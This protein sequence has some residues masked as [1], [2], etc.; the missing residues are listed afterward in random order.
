VTRS[1]KE[2]FELS[3]GLDE[4]KQRFINRIHNQVWLNYFFSLSENETLSL[5]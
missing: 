3:I 1:F 4:A 2:R 5:H